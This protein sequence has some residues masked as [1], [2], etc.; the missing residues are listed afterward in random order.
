MSV[1]AAAAPRARLTPRAAVLAALILVLALAMVVPVR[2]YFEQRADIA[3]LERTVQELERQ[4][5]RMREEI[6]RLHDPAYLERLARECLGMVRP[7]EIAF[8][9]VPEGGR[10]APPRC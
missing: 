2:Q 8:V 6:E 3:E 10:P 1:R 7:G 4:R 9:P 5:A